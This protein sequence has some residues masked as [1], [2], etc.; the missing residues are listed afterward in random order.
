MCNCCTTTDFRNTCWIKK[1]GFKNC[2]MII[3]SI[4][5]RIF[6]D[7]QLNK[8]IRTQGFNIILKEKCFLSTNIC[9]FNSLRKARQP[10]FWQWS[11]SSNHRYKKTNID[12]WR[13]VMCPLL[14]LVFH[15]FFFMR[16]LT[17]LMR[18]TRQVKHTIHQSILLRCLWI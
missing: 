3:H 8:K 13:F 12:C 14:V 17:V 15:G 1:P 11:V 6:E 10:R 2:P 16:P 7:Y 18:Q 5:L 4:L 9:L